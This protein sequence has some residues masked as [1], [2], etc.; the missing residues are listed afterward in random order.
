MWVDKNSEFYNGPIK[1]CLEKILL[2][3]KRTKVIN[4]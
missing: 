1:S 2:E 3:T 4:T